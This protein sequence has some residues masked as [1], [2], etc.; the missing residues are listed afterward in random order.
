MNNCRKCDTKILE[1]YCSN[2]G[3][4]AIVKKLDFHYISH[5]IQHLFHLEKGFFL[6]TKE[7]L[8]R[9]GKVVRE[10]ILEDR[11]KQVKP[12]IFL[13]FASLI[14]TIVVHYFHLSY[15]YLSINDMQLKEKNIDL[16]FVDNWL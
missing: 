9:P 7:L 11:V 15:Q 14:F 16:T 2:C 13:I 1:N 6:I 4:S 10:Y 12:V 8:I 5:E 3:Q